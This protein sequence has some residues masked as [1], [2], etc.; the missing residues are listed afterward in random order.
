MCPATAA[1]AG[2]AA[3]ADWSLGPHLSSILLPP[4]AHR[5]LFQQAKERVLLR[6]RERR[7]TARHD[8]RRAFGRVQERW[9]AAR[10]SLRTYREEQKERLR[11]YY[12]SALA[13]GAVPSSSAAEVAAPPLASRSL[14]QAAAAAAEAGAL[15]ARAAAAALGTNGPLRVRAWCWH[16]Y[17][18]PHAR[19]WAG[20]RWLP[21]LLPL[22]PAAMNCSPRSTWCWLA[23]AAPAS[24]LCL[25]ALAAAWWVRSVWR[26]RWIA[27]QG[28]G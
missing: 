20:G 7:R 11:Q 13:G 23:W 1:A 10:L 26:Q 14:P 16:R 22:T 5:S 18:R 6:L 15:D 28:G 27:S 12:A 21:A 3:A 24:S 9:A 19:V 8:P 2:G 17:W 4:L 25:Q